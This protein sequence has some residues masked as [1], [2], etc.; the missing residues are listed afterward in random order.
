MTATAPVIEVRPVAAPPV[1]SEESEGCLVV[2]VKPEH[3]ARGTRDNVYSCAVALALK[4]MGFGDANV[5][6]SSTRAGGR[7]WWNSDALT[8][9]I[10]HFDHGEPVSPERFVLRPAGLARPNPAAVA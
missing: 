6:R 4:E 9:W 1:E 2:V 8:D 5:S 10:D 7:W 3:I